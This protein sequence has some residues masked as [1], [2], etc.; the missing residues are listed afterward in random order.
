MPQSRKALPQASVHFTVK[1]FRIS[2]S[3]TQATINV[4]TVA[5]RPPQDHSQVRLPLVEYGFEGWPQRQQCIHDLDVVHKGKRF[6][7]FFQRH[8]HLGW[9]STLAVRGDLVIMR[10]GKKNVKNV[11]NFRSGDAKCARLIARRFAP[12]LAWFQSRPG[13][14][15]ESVMQL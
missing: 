14:R 1:G 7:V 6:R 15:L 9:N 2:S 11:V 12:R 4:V 5:S 3:N 13:R 10:V 8:Q